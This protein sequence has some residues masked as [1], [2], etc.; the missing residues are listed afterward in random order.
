MP[1]YK[2]QL[3]VW[4]PLQENPALDNKLF[5]PTEEHR[6]KYYGTTCLMAGM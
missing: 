3:R 5:K 4:N 6:E 2:L 1:Y